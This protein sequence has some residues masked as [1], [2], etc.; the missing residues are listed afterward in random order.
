LVAKITVTFVPGVPTDLA[1][2]PAVQ[3][4]GEDDVVECGVAEP[5]RPA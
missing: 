5:A 4:V 3:L 2:R 1:D